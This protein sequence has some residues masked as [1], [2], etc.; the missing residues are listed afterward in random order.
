M[1]LMRMRAWRPYTV[2]HHG[3][4]G[5]PAVRPGNALYT[6][7]CG[8]RGGR[9]GGGHDRALPADGVTPRTIRC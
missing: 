2:D 3:K 4:V 9:G 7:G 5:F 8:G 1:G 6:H